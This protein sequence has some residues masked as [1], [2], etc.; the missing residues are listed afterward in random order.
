VLS[1]RNTIDVRVDTYDC[2]LGEDVD[3]L[4]FELGVE[5]R[6]TDRPLRCVIPESFYLSS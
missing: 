4:R 5:N 6:A 3:N 2:D 1:N